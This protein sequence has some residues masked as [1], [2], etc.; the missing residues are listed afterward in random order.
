MH[1]HK[2]NRRLHTYQAGQA[3]T[4][5]HVAARKEEEEGRPAHATTDKDTRPG[6]GT[7]SPRRVSAPRLTPRSHLGGL[8]KWAVGSGRRSAARPPARACASSPA[9]RQAAA[10]RQERWG[11]SGSDT[12]ANG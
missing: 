6:P 2:Y 10:W 12:G 1:K 7:G 5:Q 8:G 11:S 3:E 4:I 9:G